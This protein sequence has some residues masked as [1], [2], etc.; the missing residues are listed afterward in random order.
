MDIHIPEPKIKKVQGLSILEKTLKTIAYHFIQGYI[1]YGPQHVGLLYLSRLEKELKVY[2]R[3]GNY[4]HLINVAVY[5][6][7]ERIAPEHP[8]HHYDP[9][10]DSITRKEFGE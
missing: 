10:S 5:V 8:K 6:I 7:L 3:T 9:Y 4:E 2:K 1:R